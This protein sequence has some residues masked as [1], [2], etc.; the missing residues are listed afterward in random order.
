MSR[1]SDCFHV[2]YMNLWRIRSN[3]YLY[4]YIKYILFVLTNV[5]GTV[6]AQSIGSDKLCM[7]DFIIEFI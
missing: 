2:A 3:I 5:K 7:L 6:T 4:I 1:E